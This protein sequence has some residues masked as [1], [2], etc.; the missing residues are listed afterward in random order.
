VAEA[1]NGVAGSNGAAAGGDSA[2]AREANNFAVAGVEGATPAARPTPRSLCAD[3][4]E[5][6]RCLRDLCTR[7]AWRNHA[8]CQALRRSQGNR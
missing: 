4:A 2:P 1:A 7:A 3:Q 8:Q 6:A 5:A